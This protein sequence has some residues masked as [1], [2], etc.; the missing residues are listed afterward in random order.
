MASDAAGHFTGAMHI[1]NLSPCIAA[2][3]PIT[4]SGTVDGNGL[5]TF[6]SAAIAN[7]IFTG[8]AA[9]SSTGVS[10]NSGTYSVAGGCAGG[11]H[12]SLSGGVVPAVTGPYNVTFAITTPSNLTL[13]FTAPLTQSGPDAGGVFHIAGTISNSGQTNCPIATIQ[14]SQLMGNQISFSAPT[15][16]DPANTT[17]NFTGNANVSSKPNVAQMSGQVSTVVGN[18]AN[19][20]ANPC[21]GMSGSAAFAP[22]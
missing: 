13:T 20:G 9:I 10:I 15:I 16:N 2:G 7:Q 18:P 22:Q 5:L 6:T 12:G 17:V 8:T 21:G 14:T 4:M 3:T 1:L 19:A 11:D